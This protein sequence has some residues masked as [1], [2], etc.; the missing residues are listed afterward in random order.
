MTDD[1]RKAR[2]AIARQTHER[3]TQRAERA[4]GREGVT[5]LRQRVKTALHER[6]RAELEASR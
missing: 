3:L 2:A 6:M 4:K 5:A 1:L